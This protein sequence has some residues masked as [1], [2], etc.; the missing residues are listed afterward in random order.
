MFP[1]FGVSHSLPFGP[2][3]AIGSIPC[4]RFRLEYFTVKISYRF[5][6]FQWIKHPDALFHVRL[7]K[8]FLTSDITD[9]NSNTVEQLG[10]VTFKIISQTFQ[11]SILQI[12]LS[13]TLLR[14]FQQEAVEISEIFP[15]VFLFRFLFVLKNRRTNE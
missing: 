15:P 5:I 8:G 2:Q 4:P 9:F 13:Y 6:T 10:K 11:H 7:V 3:M 1:V 12:H 14:V